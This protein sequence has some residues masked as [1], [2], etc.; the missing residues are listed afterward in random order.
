MADEA[1]VEDIEEGEDGEAEGDQALVEDA[2]GENVQSTPAADYMY[3]WARERVRPVSGKRITKA[4]YNSHDTFRATLPNV[5]DRFV[6]D[7][8]PCDFQG[9]FEYVKNGNL[10]TTAIALLPLLFHLADSIVY[11]FNPF[12]YK[13]AWACG[14]KVSISCMADCLTC[15]RSDGN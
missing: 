13:K 9:L 6:F 10:I 5:A 12:F 15:C 1:D 14:P 7:M 4:T 11:V 2:P 3:T 8:K